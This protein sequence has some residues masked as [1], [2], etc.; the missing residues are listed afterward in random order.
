SAV[1]PAVLIAW[2][3]A[4]VSGVEGQGDATAGEEAVKAKTLVKNWDELE[5]ALEEVL[6]SSPEDESLEG[7]QS[8]QLFLELE[9]TE[10]PILWSAMLQQGKMPM[11]QLAGF[12]LFNRNRP[13]DAMRAALTGIAAAE[14]PSIALY[15]PLYL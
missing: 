5:E 3:C 15:V 8:S 7:I 2:A 11:V 10:N 6:R 14:N 1:V 4:S 12:Y 13:N 9:A